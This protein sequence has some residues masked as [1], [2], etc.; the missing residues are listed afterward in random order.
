M[1]YLGIFRIYLVFK[2][3]SYLDLFKSG[4]E[5]GK[6]QF[7]F[8][9]VA[10]CFCGKVGGEAIFGP[11]ARRGSPLRAGSLCLRGIGGCCSRLRPGAAPIAGLYS[12]V[13]CPCRSLQNEGET[14]SPEVP[15]AGETFVGPCPRCGHS[16]ERGPA[17]FRG[18]P[19]ARA[20]VV[21]RSPYGSA[22]VRHP[23]NLSP[24]RRG[25]VL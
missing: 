11:L 3:S 22:K 20:R 10:L 2:M 7:L 19:S 15:K 1:L 16:R 14:P 8:P 17:R 24:R 12:F 25:K 13:R 6:L 4:T 18:F 5:E 9:S 23:Q 21:S